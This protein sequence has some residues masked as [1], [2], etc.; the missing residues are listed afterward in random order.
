MEKK[1]EELMDKNRRMGRA[2]VREIRFEGFP[3]PN[4]GLVHFNKD[5]MVDCPTT[6]VQAIFILAGRP[7]AM[8]SA[9]LR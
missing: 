5:R 9:S 2:Y 8:D 1:I 6:V 7:W 4:L 3:F